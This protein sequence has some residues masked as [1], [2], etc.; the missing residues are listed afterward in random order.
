LSHLGRDSPC[1]GD[2]P[3]RVADRGA[4]VAHDRLGKV[5]H[6]A[7]LVD[8][9]SRPREQRLHLAAV[10]LEDAVDR[11][12]DVAALHEDAA[13]EVA[14]LSKHVG[15][16][17]DELEESGGDEIHLGWVGPEHRLVERQRGRALGARGDAQVLLAEH[18]AS[19]D[20]ELGVG[21][22]QV[23]RA[24]LHPD[25]ELDELALAGLGVHVA[26][27]E[28]PHLFH[29]PDPDP[30]DPHRGAGRDVPGA[31]E[32]DG[33]IETLAHR[34]VAEHHDEPYEQGEG[35]EDEQSHPNLQA[36][37]FH[38]GLHRALGLTGDVLADDRVIGSPEVRGCAVEQ[39]LPLI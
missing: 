25:L 26:V 32:G 9:L 13:D 5:E 16:V 35:D 11:L 7:H 28:E 36:L 29:L 33:E 34:E 2:E 18:A 10:L 39:E 23:T 37:V 4:H 31:R 20:V 14:V 21:A 27:G 1:I 3:A 12:H 8:R 6:P 24:L 17:L 38:S 15:E 30:R 22:Q 19:G